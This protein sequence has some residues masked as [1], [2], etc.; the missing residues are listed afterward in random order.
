MQFFV[1]TIHCAII[2][3]FEEVFE[4]IGE[5]PLYEECL[6]SNYAAHFHSKVHHEKDKI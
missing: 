2:E 1:G 4:S 3:P 5:E 6:Y